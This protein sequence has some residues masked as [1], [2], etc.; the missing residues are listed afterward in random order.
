[1]VCHSA[2]HRAEEHTGLSLPLYN[3]ISA[4]AAT[5]DPDG[6]AL[7]A[8]VKVRG[9]LQ[10]FCKPHIHLHLLQYKQVGGQEIPGQ[11]LT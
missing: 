10:T 2:W 6:V 3:S 4:L 5:H 9:I 1:M 11:T 8:H 7:A